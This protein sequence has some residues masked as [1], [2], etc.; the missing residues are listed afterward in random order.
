MIRVRGTIKRIHFLRGILMIHCEFELN[1]KRVSQFKYANRQAEAFSGNGVHTNRL[2][3]VCMPSIG[4]IPPGKYYIVDRQSGGFLGAL[5]DFLENKSQWFSLYAIDNKI[6]DVAYCEA[7]KR[8]QFRLHPKGP[9]GR[10]EGCITIEKPADFV[11]IRAM[12]KGTN[13][14]NIPNTEL[15]AYGMVVVK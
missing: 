2:Q 3:S 10:S 6:D 15:Q 7:V 13:T 14:V 4:P 5:Y 1:N 9:L 11:Q 8:G 12:L